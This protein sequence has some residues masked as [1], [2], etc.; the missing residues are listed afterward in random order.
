M[1]TVLADKRFTTTFSLEIAAPGGAWPE[2]KL[3][4]GARQALKRSSSMPYLWTL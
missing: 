3:N 1:A 4:G 2:W